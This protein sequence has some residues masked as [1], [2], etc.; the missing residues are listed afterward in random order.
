MA[1]PF[2]TAVDSQSTPIGDGTAAALICW[3][4]DY[5]IALFPRNN[6]EYWSRNEW[7]SATEDLRPTD[8]VPISGTGENP[9]VAGGCWACHGASEARE[10]RVYLLRQDHR[11]Q[12]LTWVKTFDTE[13]TAWQMARAL[14]TALESYFRF[15][16]LPVL[17][18]ILRA[19]PDHARTS[20]TNDAPL[21]K[22]R[23]EASPS[24][25]RLV[26]STDKVYFSR[27]LKGPGSE[28]LAKAY[29][30]DCKRV[31]NNLGVSFTQVLAPCFQELRELAD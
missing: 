31:L 5:L 23:I 29:L 16:E 4:E 10:L 6:I 19:L 11:A 18:A 21:P 13:E 24:E 15:K 2:F 1:N 30:A 25:F 26:D 28:L 9:F 20:R 17:V 3:L 7:S 12:R 27:A 22:L 14:Q 8:A